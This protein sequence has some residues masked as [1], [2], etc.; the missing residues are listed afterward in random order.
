MLGALH[1][2]LTS[3]Q[4]ISS[5]NIESDNL[6]YQ[7]LDLEDLVEEDVEVIQEVDWDLEDEVADH[8]LQMLAKKVSDLMCFFFAN[9]LIAPIFIRF[10]FYMPRFGLSPQQIQVFK[11]LCATFNKSPRVPP[12]DIDICWN[13]TYDVL[14]F[15]FNYRLV[16]E[17]FVTRDKKLNRDTYLV[18]E[19]EWQQI[20]KMMPIL[21]V[22]GIWFL[23]F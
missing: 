12:I 1:I 23:Y 9:T 6:P 14:K 18:S 8:P 19:E 7:T 5:R 21:E 13:S 2:S 10:T 3:L 20:Q 22:S 15:G 16:L 11:A 17:A 4:R